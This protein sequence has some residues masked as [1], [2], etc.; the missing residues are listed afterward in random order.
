MPCVEKTCLNASTLILL[1]LAVSCSVGRGKTYY[2]RV[3]QHNT[4]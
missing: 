3:E 1:M 2:V 4:V